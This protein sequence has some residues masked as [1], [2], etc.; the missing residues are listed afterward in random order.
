MPCREP[1]ISAVRHGDGLWLLRHSLR[2][3][4]RR[5]QA[6]TGARIASPFEVHMY[7]VCA[8]GTYAPIHEE[9]A[10]NPSAA[11]ERRGGDT[12]RR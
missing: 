3:S 4:L 7:V 1:D 11:I 2:Q 10:T 6:T 9:A 8:C 12:G 5:D